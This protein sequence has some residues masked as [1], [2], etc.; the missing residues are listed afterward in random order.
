MDVS[1]LAWLLDSDPAVAWQAIRDLED[2]P[3]VDW[4]GVRVRVETEGWGAELLSHRDPDGQWAG[5]A[6]VP[7][8]FTPELWK[9]E[10]QPWTA[11]TYALTDLRD[12]GVLPDSE[13]ARETV[14]LVGRNS[15]WDHDGQPFW[16]GEVEECIN[17]RTVAAGAYFGVDV[18]SIV[19]RL[20]GEIQPDGGWNCERANGSTKTSFD[21]T[22]NV[23][24]GLLEFERSVG[25]DADV[26]AAREGAE[27]WLLKRGLFR[28][29]STGEPA[30]SD[31]MALIHPPRWMYTA[32]RALDH[33]RSAGV[34]HGTRPDQRLTDAVDHIRSRQL[35]DGRWPVDRTPK[36]RTW[37]EMAE[38]PGSPSP[39][40]TLQAMRVLRWF[41]S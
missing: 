8:G 25:G 26:R 22:I 4:M 36:G 2:R 40:V 3:E 15:R 12:F 32:L 13:V 5:G 14:E 41:E 29:L 16:E 28:R 18:S 11:T 20:L 9:E 31:F 38:G 23:V 34:L 35:D 10:G 24:E 27:E 17:G 33:F 19:D 30:H 1:I 37:F 7:A 21:T 6:F 39:W